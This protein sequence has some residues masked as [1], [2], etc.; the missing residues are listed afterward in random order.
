M[1]TVKQFITVLAIVILSGCAANPFV[2]KQ[3]AVQSEYV[4]VAPDGTLITNVVTHPGY[5]VAPSMK[6]LEP[7]APL[8]G[9]WGTL[10]VSLAGIGAAAAVKILN[11]RELNKHIEESEKS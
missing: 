7:V 1:K 5:A 9:P 8:F 11:T 4:T 6:A 10:A 3:P 2:V